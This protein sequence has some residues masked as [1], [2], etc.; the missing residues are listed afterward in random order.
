M[1]TSR[2]SLKYWI[3]A[4]LAAL[5]LTPATAQADVGTPLMWAT[6]LHLFIGNLLIGIFEGY[7]LAKFF[8]LPKL[9]SI[10]LMI[11]ANYV[12]MWLGGLLLLG[13]LSS[14]IPVDLSSG[15]WI[16]PGL[17]LLSFILTLLME[18]PFVFGV[19]KGVQGKW[20]TAWKGTLLTQS[21]SYIILFGWY[22]MT[23]HATLYTENKVV[24]MSEMELPK[25]VTIYFI[26]VEDGYVYS[27]NLSEQNWQK[28]YDLDKKD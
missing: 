1:K 8:K 27:G 23:S 5:L 24:S 11:I 2:P 9:R 6:L 18:Y 15:R 10:I 4:G 20:K 7:L 17:I 16:Y 3:F 26:S 28:V 14:L 19:F 22:G 12:S 21:L 25:E 13:W